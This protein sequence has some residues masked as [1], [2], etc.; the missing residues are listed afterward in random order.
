MAGVFLDTNIILLHLLGHHPELSLRA[1]T[2]L[3]RIEREEIEVHIA[4]TVIFEAVF[5]LQRHYRHPKEKIRDAI[6]PLIELPNIILPGKRR[7]R[8]VFDLYVKY[9]ISFADA[10]H[11]VLMDHLKLDTIV[12]FDHDFDRVPGMI[13]VEP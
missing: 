10:Y 9:N 7:F 12:T 13:R 11:A 5:T 4:D 1:T 6:L 8:Q 3:E 2:Y